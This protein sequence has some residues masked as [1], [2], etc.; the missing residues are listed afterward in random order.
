M[1]AMS[2]KCRAL[3]YSAVL[4]MCASAQTGAPAQTTVSSYT[5][6]QAVA[7]V[8]PTINAAIT[9]ATP[10]PCAAPL[11]DTLTGTT[12]TGTPCMARPDATRPTQVNRSSAVTA[13]DGSFTG[14]WRP[15]QTALPSSPMTVVAQA[16]TVS[17]PYNCQVGAWTTTS[18]TGKCWKLTASTLPATA[19]ALPGFIVS[20]FTP[21]ASGVP[22]SIVG[23]Q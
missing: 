1:F 13:T 19:V 4:C 16:N 9:A 23:R 20:P 7:A 21:S 6:A 12:G 14:F 2:R 8:G 15:D 18:F 5:D 22:V 11:G 17:D 10:T 3:F